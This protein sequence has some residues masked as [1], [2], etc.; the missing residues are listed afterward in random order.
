[1]TLDETI[2]LAQSACG[3]TTFSFDDAESGAQKLLSAF[4]WAASSTPNVAIGA[5]HCLARPDCDFC[6]HSHHLFLPDPAA[7]TLPPLPLISLIRSVSAGEALDFTKRKRAGSV[8]LELDPVLSDDERRAHIAATGGGAWRRVQRACVPRVRSHSRRAFSR[9]IAAPRRGSN[10]N[11]RQRHGAASR[12]AAAILAAHFCAAGRRSQGERH[13]QAVRV[14][15]QG[16]K[17]QRRS[18][19]DVALRRRYV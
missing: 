15:G 8:A 6:E 11:S 17:G 9:A 3:L 13:D 18:A 19:F 1:V 12:L 5:C 10:S 4:K 16:S 2:R 14:D 7:P